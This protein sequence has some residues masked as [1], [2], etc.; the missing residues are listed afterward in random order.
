MEYYPIEVI[1]AAGMNDSQ[2]PK[3]KKILQ[4]Y[5]DYVHTTN[6]QGDNALLLAVK[7][8]N[9]EIAKFLITKT[10]I[11]IHYKNSF[12]NALNIAIQY[13]NHQMIFYLLK[14]GVMIEYPYIAAIKGNNEI[15]VIK[16]LYKLKYNINEKNFE[17]NAFTLAVQNNNTK[18]ALFL[19]KNGA[20]INVPNQ[21]GIHPYLIS[22]ENFNV[23]L[24]DFY[25]KNDYLE[26]VDVVTTLNSSPF[27]KS[28]LTTLK[29]LS[30]DYRFSNK[31]FYK[32]WKKTRFDLYDLKQWEETICPHQALLL[33]DDK[34]LSKFKFFF[35]HIPPDFQLSLRKYF[36]DIIQQ[37]Y[38]YVPKILNFLQ[39]PPLFKSLSKTLKVNTSNTSISKI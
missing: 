10:L 11:D 21:K 9:N 31:S 29:T 25:T 19:L 2:L 32:V 17:G 27:A 22:I 4:A 36:I 28:P 1:Q 8:G 24:A 37:R 34:N 5:P 38:L 18:C 3:L 6:P 7:E 35:K 16:T 20:D 12:G 30:L 39:H 33:Q 23:L 26:K 13:N 15:H 14:L